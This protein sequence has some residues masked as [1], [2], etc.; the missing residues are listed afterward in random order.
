MKWFKDRLWKRPKQ[1]H[2]LSRFLP[3][4]TGLV[5]FSV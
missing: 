1:L 5:A 2:S 4:S 3:V